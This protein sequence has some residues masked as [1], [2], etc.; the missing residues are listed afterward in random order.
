MEEIISL[1]EAMDFFTELENENE[2]FLTDNFSLLQ[3]IEQ[4]LRELEY[5][6]KEEEEIDQSISFFSPVGVLD[7][8]KE[9][10]QKKE[11]EELKE[12]QE[13]L[14]KQIEKQKAK[15][16]IIQKL[17]N[18][19][20]RVLKEGNEKSCEKKA[21]Y[22]LETQEHDRNRI[23]RDLHDTSVQTL[24]NLVHKSE[25]C[26]RLIDMDTIRVK[27]ELQTMIENIRS[28]INDMRN[29][30]YDLKP[31][32]LSEVTLTEAI[33]NFCFQ[34]Q[35]LFDVDFQ[36]DLQE[37]KSEIL[38]IIKITLYRIIQEAC[39]NIGKHAKTK[40]AFISIQ[41]EKGMILLK[42]KDNGIGFDTSICNQDREESSCFGISIM[43]ERVSLLGGTFSLQSKKEEG[44]EIQIEVPVVE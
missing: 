35:K 15:Q 23:A 5:S 24:T 28:V 21:L 22:I 4:S 6:M 29:I 42:I 7:E 17:K 41:Y 13:K 33:E 31:M 36:L 27:L 30:I 11:L 19:M 26:I 12:K 43:K 3:E 8:K 37:E 18:T 14:I 10:E 32:A 2:A 9:N 16:I 40:K 38:P 25:L 39:I 1:E 34:Q 44:T 20:S